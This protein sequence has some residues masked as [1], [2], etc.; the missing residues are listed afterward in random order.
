MTVVEH[1]RGA[2]HSNADALS[3]QPC[4]PAGCKYCE[5]LEDTE[6]FQKGTLNVF[7]QH[8]GYE[9]KGS[10][11]DLHIGQENDEIVKAYWSQLDSLQLEEGMLFR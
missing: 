5:R 2:K 8:A 11:E 3:R 9:V 1:R 4:L 10:R 7:Y 6:E